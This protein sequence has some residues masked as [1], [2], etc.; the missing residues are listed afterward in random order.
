MNSPDNWSFD[1]YLA[2]YGYASAVNTA[3]DVIFENY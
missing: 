2:G 1:R 3:G